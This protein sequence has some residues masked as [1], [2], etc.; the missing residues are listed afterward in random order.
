MQFN[1]P[2]VT[3]LI[4]MLIIVVNIEVTIHYPLVQVPASVLYI[5]IYNF[6]QNHTV[7][8]LMHYVLRQIF[9]YLHPAHGISRPGIVKLSKRDVSNKVYRLIQK[10]GQSTQPNI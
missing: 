9:T 5:V 6:L 3:Y 8:A 2:A 4:C 1:I 7:I 10:T